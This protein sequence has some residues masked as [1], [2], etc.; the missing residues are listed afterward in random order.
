VAAFYEK[1]YRESF[2]C[3]MRLAEDAIVF[4]Q[5]RRQLNMYLRLRIAYESGGRDSIFARM[6]EMCRRFKSPGW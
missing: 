6:L 2:P 1:V 5:H 3:G 4:Q